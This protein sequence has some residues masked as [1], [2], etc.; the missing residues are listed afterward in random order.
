MTIEQRYT[1]LRNLS[2][3]RETM[4]DSVIDLNA[5]IMANNIFE[6]KMIKEIFAEY[7]QNYSLD[8]IKNFVL[9]LIQ[10]GSVGI[11][12][13]KISLVNQ[14]YALMIHKVLLPDYL[15]EASQEVKK[16]ELKGIIERYMSRLDKKIE[17]IKQDPFHIMM[18][19]LEE[20]DNEIER[21]GGIVT[22]NFR[23]W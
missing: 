22:R 17:T 11:A 14:F 4:S 19:D 8:D 23:S 20:L 15:Q 21:M 5:P 1:Q 10:F 13:N 16:E 6:E 3:S 18:G 2:L 12:Q 9:K 7:I